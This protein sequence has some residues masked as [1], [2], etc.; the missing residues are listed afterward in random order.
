MPAQGPCAWLSEGRHVQGGVSLT[1]GELWGEAGLERQSWVSL[2]FPK[3]SSRLAE[4]C[5]LCEPHWEA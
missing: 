2:H 3:S 1:D 5:G 4:E